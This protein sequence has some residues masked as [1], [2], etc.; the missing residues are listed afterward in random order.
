MCRAACDSVLDAILADAAANTVL[1]QAADSRDTGQ[2]VGGT[3]DAP[4]IAEAHAANNVVGAAQRRATRNPQTSSVRAA[5]ASHADMCSMLVGWEWRCA[6]PPR[7]QPSD[8]SLVHHVKALVGVSGM[9]LG[10]VTFLGTEHMDYVHGY[11]FM[12]IHVSLVTGVLKLVD[13]PL[14]KVK[15][16]KKSPAVCHVQVNG[17]VSFRWGSKHWLDPVSS[18]VKVSGDPKVPP[19]K[20]WQSGKG[21]QGGKGLV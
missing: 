3:G 20:P 8:A 17:E 2:P 16:T 4:N 12:G 11:T 7:E 5:P 15:K 6:G 13:P 10:M 14:Q 18:K 1:R 9:A 21:G 19:E